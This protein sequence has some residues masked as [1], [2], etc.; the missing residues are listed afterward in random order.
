MVP[1][2]QRKRT[3]ETTGPNSKVS[4]GLLGEKLPVA[5]GGG[6]GAADPRPEARV[7]K[8]RDAKKKKREE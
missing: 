3:K 2:L 1:A 7:R 8:E 6:D 4:R 5:A